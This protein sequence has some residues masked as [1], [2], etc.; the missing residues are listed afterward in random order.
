V[1]ILSGTIV[2]AINT[3]NTIYVGVDSKIISIGA[4]VTAIT[5][6]SD[7]KLIQYGDVVF[8]H[9]GIFRD[10]RGT[11]DLPASVRA[12]IEAVGELETVV[13]RFIDRIQH[14]LSGAL[15]EIRWQNPSYFMEKLKRPVEVLFA[16]AQGG[17]PQQIVVSFEVIDPSA[18][19]LTFRVSRLRYPA[20]C[21]T[22][23]AVIALGEHGEADRF[24]DNH[25]EILRTRGPIAAIQ[26]AIADQA[27]ATPDFVSLPTIMVTIDAYGIH[28][29]N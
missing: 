2:L 16:S 21:Q 12:S 5:N 27:R 20:D 6:N 25:M 3:P 15:L 17:T 1:N 8:A 26:G 10:I 7:R 23:G 29:L 9:V 11:F 28:F 19:H 24:F 4:E 13:D 14:D 22:Y 18:S